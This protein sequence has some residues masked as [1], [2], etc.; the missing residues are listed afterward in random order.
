MTLTKGFLRALSKTSESPAIVLSKINEL[1][2]EN[3]ERGTFISMIYGI[4]D[5]ER[6]VFKFA[7]AGHNPVIAKKTISGN[8]EMLN[9][10][11]MALGL[12]KGLIFSKTIKEQEVE[13]AA[14][15]IFVLYTDGFT[16]AMDKKQQEFGVDRLS[17]IVEE[18]S[19]FNAGFLLNEIFKDVKVFMGK[20]D[21]H[22]DMTMVIIKIL[23]NLK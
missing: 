10:T 20:A 12:E 11:G 19:S 22:D 15:D 5:T 18:K 4:F 9:P 16:E 13:V 21:Q 17:K 23:D 8:I 7:R 2:Y 6:K 14:G 1:F 3:V